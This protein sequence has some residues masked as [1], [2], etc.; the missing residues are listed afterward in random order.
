MEMGATTMRRIAL[1]HAVYAAIRPVQDAFEAHWPEVRLVSLLDDSL[2]AD[3][4]SA[5]APT[6]ELSRRIMALAKY[7][8]EAGAA[9]ILFTCSAFGEAIEAAARVLPIPVLKP[10]E[11]MFNLALDQ[12]GRVGMLATFGPAIASMEDEFRDMA[13]RRGST[14]TIESLCVPA[15]RAA[16]LAGDGDGHDLLLAEAAPQMQAC[17]CVLLAHF[18]TARAK[19]VVEAKLGRRV[20]TSPDSAVVKLRSCFADAAHPAAIGQS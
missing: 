1:I 13:R 10:N 19:A 11:A 9:G 18:S 12:G 6:P 15:A 17:D 3:R 2:P 5:G 7:S 14:A 4:E 8:M 16:L 20:L